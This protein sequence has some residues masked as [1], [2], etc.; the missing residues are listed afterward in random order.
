MDND[1]F[2]YG[3]GD[4]DVCGQ[5][6]ILIARDKKNNKMLVIC[7]D[8]ESQWSSPESYQQGHNSLPAEKQHEHVVDAS[9]AEIKQEDWNGYIEEKIPRDFA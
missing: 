8:C 9:L 1:D 5:G 2:S 7:N 4:C 3:I 6:M